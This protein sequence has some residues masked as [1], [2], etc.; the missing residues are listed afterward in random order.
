[1][2]QGAGLPIS[3]E[4]HGGS[5]TESAESAAQLVRDVGLPN[6]ST[7]WQT[8]VGMDDAGCVASLAQVLP[9]VSNVHV[10]HWGASGWND[11]RPLH[12]ALPRWKPLMAMLA[13]TGREHFLMLE[14]V[15]DDAPENFLRDAATLRAMLDARA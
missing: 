13:T 3:F 15:P 9:M 7:L 14:Y 11:R 8:P 10:F 12:E 5:L 4:F 1:M 2:A 6:V